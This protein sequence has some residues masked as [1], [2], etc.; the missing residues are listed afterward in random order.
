MSEL[1]QYVIYERPSDHPEGY[2][3]RQWR[4]TRHGAQPEG[5]IVADSLQAARDRVPLGKVCLD[6]QP[7]DDPC[8]VEV[9]T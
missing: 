6:R 7:D 5:Y 1:V 4:I 8:I 9:W 3:V 2:V